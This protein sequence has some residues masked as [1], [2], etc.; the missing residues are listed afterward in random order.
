MS[1][2][3]IGRRQ[4][5]KEMR[6]GGIPGVFGARFS[7]FVLAFCVPPEASVAGDPDEQVRQLAVEAIAVI[8]AEVAARAS[9]AALPGGSG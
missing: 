6:T 1:D 5:D 8:E 2:V 7:L 4:R 3:Q 9:A